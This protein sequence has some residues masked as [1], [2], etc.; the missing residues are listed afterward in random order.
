[1]A[2]SKTIYTPTETQPC[3]R[4]PIKNSTPKKPMTPTDPQSATARPVRNVNSRPTVMG[5]VVPNQNQ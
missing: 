5:P 4:T 1:M 3:V 2:G